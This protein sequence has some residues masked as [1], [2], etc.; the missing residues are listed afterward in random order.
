[1]DCDA[2]QYGFVKETE[3][4]SLEIVVGIAFAS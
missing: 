2:M 3:L 4:S 1:M